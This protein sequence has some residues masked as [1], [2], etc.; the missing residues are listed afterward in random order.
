MHGVGH[1]HWSL[2]GKLWGEGSWRLIKYGGASPAKAGWLG[3]QTY[4]FVFGF[5]FQSMKM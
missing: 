5:V 2:Y 4:V 3:F 1:S